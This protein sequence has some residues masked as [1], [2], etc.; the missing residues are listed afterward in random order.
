[1]LFQSPTVISQNE[2]PVIVLS[3][4]KIEYQVSFD[5]LLSNIGDAEHQSLLLMT[6]S[7]ENY[8]GHGGSILALIQH[9]ESPGL[10]FRYQTSKTEDIGVYK[11][12][13]ISIRKWINIMVVQYFDGSSFIHLIRV[14]GKEVKRSNHS[15]CEDFYGVK[16]YIG[17]P[18]EKPAKGY[19][20]NLHISG[21]TRKSFIFKIFLMH[22]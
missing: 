9:S 21:M 11:H 2:K 10:T 17:A 20:R 5:V 16:I 4:L 6:T 12:P 15:Q 8:K 1:M 14:G 22:L 19:L 18:W 3:Q 13:A 7:D